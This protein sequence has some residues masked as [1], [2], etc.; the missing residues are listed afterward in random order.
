MQAPTIHLK[1]SANENADILR[2][3][4]NTLRD[5]YPTYS[6]EPRVAEKADCE[7][8]MQPFERQETTPAEILA[9]ATLGLVP[10]YRGEKNIAAMRIK[11]FADTSRAHTKDYMLTSR[12]LI[13][14][15]LIFLLVCEEEQ[16][17]TQYRRILDD[18]FYNELPKALPLP[19]TTSP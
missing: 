14:L 4:A 8:S 11:C 6:S 13:W 18:F 17:R 16:I 5:D 10:I 9:V 1:G 12:V 7:I 19:G 15:P 2:I 3:L